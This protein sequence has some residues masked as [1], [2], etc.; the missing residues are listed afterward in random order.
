MFFFFVKFYPQTNDKNEK[1]L[2]VPI[3]NKTKFFRSA[4]HEKNLFLLITFSFI[5]LYSRHN[6]ILLLHTQYTD[7]LDKKVN[8]VDFIPSFLYLCIQKRKIFTYIL[9]E[10]NKKPR[11]HCYLSIWGMS[12]YN[13]HLFEI[14]VVAHE[15]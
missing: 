8:I 15:K 9:D 11:K 5:W 6:K 7:K 12:I 2:Y 4:F 13:R 14:Y 1:I 10:Y 3:N